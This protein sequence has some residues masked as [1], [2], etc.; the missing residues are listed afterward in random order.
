MVYA[1]LRVQYGEAIACNQNEVVVILDGEALGGE[2]ELKK[3]VE[4]RYTMYLAVDYYDEI[5]KEFVR[6]VDSSKV[7]CVPT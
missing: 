5:V 3:Y 7:C 6:F 4:E 1:E 2:V